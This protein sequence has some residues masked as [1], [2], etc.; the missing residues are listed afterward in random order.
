MRSAPCGVAPTRLGAFPLWRVAEL[1]QFTGLYAPLEGETAA[2]IVA[3]RGAGQVLATPAEMRMLAEWG[4]LVYDEA[5]S[6]RSGAA[7]SLAFSWHRE[8]GIAGFCDDIGVYLTGEAIVTSCQGSSLPELGRPRLDSQQLANLYAWV[9]S[10]APFEIEWTDPATADAM[11]IHLVFAGQGTGEAGA[12]RAAG[13]PGPGRRAGP[14]GRDS[15]RPGR[16]RPRL[17]RP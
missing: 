13:N 10:L 7:W 12:Y 2:G 17:S 14:P 6:G 1:E 9:D 5:V 8:G 11:T 16:R 15:R 3:F 4:K